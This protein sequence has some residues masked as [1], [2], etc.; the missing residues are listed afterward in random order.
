MTM[1]NEHI[2][3]RGWLVIAASLTLF[4]AMTAPPSV[5]FA[6]EDNS[7][8]DATA[9]M[10]SRH[11]SP[12]SR[13]TSDTTEAGFFSTRHRQQLYSE[14]RLH[15]SGAVW[16]TA[17][18]PGL[19]NFYAQ[20]YFL[21]GLNASLMGFAALLIPYGLVTAQPAFSWVGGGFAG[22]AYTSGFITSYFGVKRYNRELRQ[23]LRISEDGRDQTSPPLAD[24]PWSMPGFRGIRIDVPF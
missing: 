11:A 23:G 4:T 8:G 12:E 1:A 19:G 16:R 15:Y 9:E 2:F 10:E 3:R 7:Q 18:L 20:Q 21:G 22:T 14:G 17:L 5:T 6:Q 24:T 13:S